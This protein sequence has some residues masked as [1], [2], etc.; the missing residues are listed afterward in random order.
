M[1]ICFAL[2][3]LALSPLCSYGQ[4]QTS[5]PFEQGSYAFFYDG[6]S[7]SVRLSAEEVSNT[8]PWNPAREDPPLSV[9]QAVKIARNELQRFVKNSADEWDISS[10]GLTQLDFEKWVYT[11]NFQCYNSRCR[12]SRAYGSFKVAV[13]MDGSIIQPKIKPDERRE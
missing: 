10:L 5:G 11:V 8:P 3:L 7:Y 4:T 12:D 9:I 1:K 13:K 2:L 6:M